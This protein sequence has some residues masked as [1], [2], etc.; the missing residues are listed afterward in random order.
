M[1]TTPITRGPWRRRGRSRPKCDRA[2]SEILARHRDKD[3]TLFDAI[4]FAVLDARRV[5]RAFTFDH[6][7]QQYG[8]IQLLG[9]PR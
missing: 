6:H 4:S 9:L 8:R 3:W 2:S 5:W 1:P 7:F